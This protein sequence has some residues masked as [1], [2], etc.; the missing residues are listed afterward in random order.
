MEYISHA[1]EIKFIAQLEDYSWVVTF[2]WLWKSVGFWY[3]L[4]FFF[5]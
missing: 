1:E 2:M 4:E 3:T 5:K